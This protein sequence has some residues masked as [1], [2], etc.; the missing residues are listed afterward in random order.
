MSAE[1]AFGRDRQGTIDTVRH[2]A[3]R[4]G[5]QL[6]EVDTLEMD[7]ARVSSGRIRESI[8]TG[9]LEQAERLLGRPYAV[10]GR[11]TASTDGWWV[12][13]PLGP[14][15]MP[16][17]GEYAVEV[18]G[19]GQVRANVDGNGRLSLADGPGGVGDPVPIR[20]EFLRPAA[21]SDVAHHATVRLS[22]EGEPAGPRS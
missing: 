16:P 22:N 6:V 19:M 2:V 8:A 18:L 14:F 17:A 13:E 15:S 11:V 7:G 9:D 12:L 4:D 10:T 20:V 21:G 3:A 5:W 1:S